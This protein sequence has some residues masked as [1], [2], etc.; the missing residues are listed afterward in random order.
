MSCIIVVV[1]Q[2]LVDIIMTGSRTMIPHITRKVSVL[3]TLTRIVE[4]IGTVYFLSMRT[5]SRTFDLPLVN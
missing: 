2:C 1:V 4:P 3:M 5:S